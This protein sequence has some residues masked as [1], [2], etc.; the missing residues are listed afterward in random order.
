LAVAYYQRKGIR[1]TPN[2]IFD[3]TNEGFE[4]IFSKLRYKGNRI[5]SP[6]PLLYH[7][8]YVSEKMRN[9]EKDNPHL[10]RMQKLRAE[11]EIIIVQHI[12]QLWKKHRD[13]WSNKGND[14]LIR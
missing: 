10:M 8:E 4:K 9:N 11:N 13:V 7:K 12:R 14:K 5:F 2:V 1:E 3:K 6:P